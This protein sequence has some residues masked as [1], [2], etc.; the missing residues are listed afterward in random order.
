MYLLDLDLIVFL[1]AGVSIAIAKNYLI[2][3][4]MIS[5]KRKTITNKLTEVLVTTTNNCMHLRF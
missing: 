4:K 2:T 1:E 5:M 3:S